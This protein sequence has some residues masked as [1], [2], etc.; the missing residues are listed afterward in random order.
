MSTIN[1]NLDFGLFVACSVLLVGF[2]WRKSNT[3]NVAVQPPVHPLDAQQIEQDL[4]TQQLSEYVK[5]DQFSIEEHIV[6][7]DTNQNNLEEKLS[8]LDHLLTCITHLYDR[9]FVDSERIIS[10]LCRVVDAIGQHEPNLVLELFQQHAQFFFTPLL[11]MQILKKQLGPLT[12]NSEFVNFIRRGENSRASNVRLIRLFG[13]LGVN[14]NQIDFIVGKEASPRT[15]NMIK[16]QREDIAKV[17]HETTQ[18]RGFRT[19]KNFL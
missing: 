17:L 1:N 19:L 18:V 14:P 5:S 4:N 16:K 13:V 15:L 6:S 7:S 2:V 12:Q 8:L 9:E 3:Q 11:M 10:C